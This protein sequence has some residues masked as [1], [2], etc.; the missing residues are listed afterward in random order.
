MILDIEP[1]LE[2][3]DDDDSPITQKSLEIFKAPKS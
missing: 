2:H 3:D 1:D